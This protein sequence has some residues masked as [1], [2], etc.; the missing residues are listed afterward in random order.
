LKLKQIVRDYPITLT[1]SVNGILLN[2]AAAFTQPTFGV[3]ALPVGARI[4]RKKKLCQAEARLFQTKPML[5]LDLIRTLVSW[6]PERTFLL[7]VDGG[8][9]A[10]RVPQPGES[11]AHQPATA[12]AS[13]RY[14]GHAPLQ[15]HAR[16]H[17]A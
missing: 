11:G 7:H 14:R 5:A 16:G 13:K 12:M 17:A 8:D 9:R 3:F 4:Y 6:L 15:R 2:F 1:V 10:I